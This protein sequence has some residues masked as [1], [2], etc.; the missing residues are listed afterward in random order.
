MICREKIVY[1][2]GE[3]DICRE[4]EINIYIKISPSL[5]LYNRL[6]NSKYNLISIITSPLY[7]SY[8]WYMTLSL[9]VTYQLSTNRIVLCSA[10][11]AFRH[12]IPFKTHPLNITPSPSIHHLLT[13]NYTS[14][15]YIIFCTLY[16]QILSLYNTP[17]L[18]IN[19]HT[20]CQL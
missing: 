12:S 1:R 6:S 20:Q 10:I 16:N 5:S 18:Y 4:K 3:G 8:L 14:I 19:P 11:L 7:I 2:E 15:L 17:I 13:Q 9:Y